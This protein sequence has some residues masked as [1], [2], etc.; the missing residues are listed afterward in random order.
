LELEDNGGEGACLE[1]LLTHHKN[2]I[3]G[4]IKMLLRMRISIAFY[5]AIRKMERQENEDKERDI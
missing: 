4:L 1:K 5:V 2:K 3:N